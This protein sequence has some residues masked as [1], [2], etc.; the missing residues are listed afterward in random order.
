MRCSKR[1]AWLLSVTPL[2]ELA[3]FV[4]AEAAAVVA[5]DQVIEQRDVEHVG[6]RRDAS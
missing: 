3:A 4:E 1:R 5:D 2:R 6:R